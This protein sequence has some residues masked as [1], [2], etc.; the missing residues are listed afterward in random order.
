MLSIRSGFRAVMTPPPRM[1]GVASV[2]RSRRRI[3]VMA[4]TEISS[5]RRLTTVRATGSSSSEARS[6]KGAR[7]VRSPSPIFP[8]WMPIVIS[9][10]RSTPKWQ[11]PSWYTAR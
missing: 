6:S 11:K 8:W 3:A 4:M 1:T 5:A 9:S 2:V 7:P 10:T